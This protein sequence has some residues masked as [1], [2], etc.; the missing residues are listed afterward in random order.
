MTDLKPGPNDF[1]H[2]DGRRCKPSPSVK[3]WQVPSGEECDRDDHPPRVYQPKNEIS[4]R[5]YPR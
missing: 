4:D 3:W 1:V 5:F 2:E